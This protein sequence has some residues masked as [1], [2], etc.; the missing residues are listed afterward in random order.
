[1]SRLT[2][3]ML[4]ASRSDRMVRKACAE[5][6]TDTAVAIWRWMSWVNAGLHALFLVFAVIA[7]LRLSCNLAP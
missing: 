5:A 3:R 6:R 1:M 7:I 2:L 4:D